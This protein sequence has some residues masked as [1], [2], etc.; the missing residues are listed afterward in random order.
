MNCEDMI[1]D[2][3]FNFSRK[4]EKYGKKL[5]N[6]GNYCFLMFSRWLVVF[7]VILFF[8]FG[9]NHIS[10][11]LDYNFFVY[12]FVRSPFIIFS[13]DFVLPLFFFYY[14]F[15]NVQNVFFY[16][17]IS[18]CSCFVILYNRKQTKKN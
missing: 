17:H 18:M 3:L 4:D 10:F 8:F 14:C 6:K 9:F 1:I 11:F 13:V 15:I 2:F 16:F 7:N 12:Y 5:L